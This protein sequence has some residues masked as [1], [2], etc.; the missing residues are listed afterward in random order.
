MKLTQKQREQLNRPRPVLFALVAGAFCLPW[1]VLFAANSYLRQQQ[2]QVDAQA[3]HFF[4][5]VLQYAGN[6]SAEQFDRLSAQLGFT[7]NAQYSTPAITDGLAAA[8]FQAIDPLLTQFLQT[9]THKISGPLDPLPLVLQQYLQQQQTPLIK[10]QQHLLSSPDPQWDVNIERL[11]DVEYRSPGFFNVHN[12]QKLLLLKVLDA[13]QHHQP[14]E[15]LAALE[16]SWRLNRAI[17]QRSDLS[18]QISLSITAAQQASIL[19][20]L[21]DVPVYWQ[22]RLLEQ[23]LQQPIMKG[24]RFEVWLRYLTSQAAWIPSFAP[25]DS[26]TD[27]ATNSATVSEKLRTTLTNRFS[28]QTYFQ[29]VSVNNTQTVHRA[30]DQLA[31]LNVCTTPQ[32]VA[33][34]IIANT[35]TAVWNNAIPLSPTVIARRWQTTGNRALA[36]ELSEYVLALKHLY[37][38]TDTWPAALPTKPSLACPGKH[39][40]YQKANDGM[41]TLSLNSQMLSPAAIPLSYRLRP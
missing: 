34:K 41:I 21:P 13:H 32:V 33:E 30:L 20:H 40:R 35:H 18:S 10:V 26:A 22:P 23:S 3:K 4:D 11:T 17:A 5:Q 16:A 19:R 9:E 28:I 14:D 1:I 8:N 12:V 31:A 6:D 38:A 15:M 37:P 29:L 27:N 24:L 2:Q 36:L 7:P 25:T 39:W